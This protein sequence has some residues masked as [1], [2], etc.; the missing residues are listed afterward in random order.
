MATPS[1]PS[2][3]KKKDPLSLNAFIEKRFSHSNYN[4]LTKEEKLEWRRTLANDLNAQ[5]FTE[6]VWNETSIIKKLSNLGIRLKQTPH[7]TTTTVGTESTV[8]PLI[9][10]SVFEQFFLASWKQ[11][12]ASASISQSC[13]DHATDKGTTNEIFLK[14]FLRTN[15]ASSRVAIGSGEIL[16]PFSSTTATSRRQCDIILY[17][18][19]LPKLTPPMGV[20]SNSEISLFFVE[21]VIAVIEVKT[22]LTNEDLIDV[23][24]SALTLSSMEIPLMLVAFDS[25]ISLSMTNTRVCPANVRGI[26][27]LHHG[28]L[29]Q[30]QQQQQQQSWQK[31]GPSTQNPL[32]LLYLSLNQAVRDYYDDNASKRHSDLDLSRYLRPI[33]NKPT[34]PTPVVLHQPPANVLE[35]KENIQPSLLLHYCHDRQHHQEVTQPRDLKLTID[36]DPLLTDEVELLSITDDED[37]R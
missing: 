28:T 18:P 12:L 11:L 34:A 5:K 32:L 26:F 22:T 17:A 20:S 23:A 4:S 35:E 21:S 30:Q 31:I 2:L 14:N 10:V 6:E 19:H 25:Q 33:T 8:T 9:P 27:N 13:F 15:F 36:E 3:R 37:T 24:S 16:F 29:L 1:T 7:Q